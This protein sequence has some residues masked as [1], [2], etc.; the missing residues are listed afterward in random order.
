MLASDQHSYWLWWKWVFVLCVYGEV[1]QVY[2]VPANF[3]NCC[4]QRTLGSCSVL[5]GFYYFYYGCKSICKY[6]RN[7]AGSKQEFSPCVKMRTERCLWG[8]VQT[9]TSASRGALGT[10]WVWGAYFGQTFLGSVQSFPSPTA[11]PTFLRCQLLSCPGS[12]VVIP[13]LTHPH[14]L[15][16]PSST[17]C[18]PPSCL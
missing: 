8:L 14:L 3:W 7:M 16:F 1:F 13:L 5:F 6:Q 2:G 4:S 9:F 11:F 12:T 15:A 10:A 17:Y 18:F